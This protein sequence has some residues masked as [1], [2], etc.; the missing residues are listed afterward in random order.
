MLRRTKKPALS[1][2]V[3]VSQRRSTWPSP[4]V[5]VKLTRVTT[6]WAGTTVEKR[7]RRNKH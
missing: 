5:A 3:A 7:S 6:A 1:I 2:S 4:A